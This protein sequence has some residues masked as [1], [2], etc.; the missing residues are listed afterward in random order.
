[1]SQ[2]PVRVV[3]AT[4][5]V[6]PIGRR[7]KE[8]DG[9]V[10]PIP[11]RVRVGYLCQIGDLRTWEPGIVQIAVAQPQDQETNL[12]HLLVVVGPWSDIPAGHEFRK[13]R[14][15]RR[16]RRDLQLRLPLPQD[17]G[18]RHPYPLGIWHGTIC[19]PTEPHLREPRA[20]I[21]L[22]GISHQVRRTEVG[23]YLPK[24]FNQKDL[25]KLELPQ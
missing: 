16:K 1:M 25:P 17:L 19:V 11:V 2:Q 5:S 14:A 13:V 21:A 3:E 8:L 22:T 18:L 15:Q 23:L 6:E 7:P 12:T 4:A 20:L 10:Q 24:S 9:Q